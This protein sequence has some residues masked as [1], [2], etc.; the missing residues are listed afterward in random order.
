MSGFDGQVIEEAIC[1]DNAG[2]EHPVEQQGVHSCAGG[3]AELQ[4]PQSDRGNVRRVS[5]FFGREG[6]AECVAQA[7]GMEF[8]EGCEHP[9]LD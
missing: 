2:F 9:T 5:E 6:V 1:G 4:I 7:D 8:E 3:R